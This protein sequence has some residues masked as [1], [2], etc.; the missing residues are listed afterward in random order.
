MSAVPYLP[1]ATEQSVFDRLVEL[2]AHSEIGNPASEI[3]MRRCVPS[4]EPSQLRRGCGKA[5]HRWLILK[6]P[7][8]AHAHMVHG[9]RGGIASTAG[10]DHATVLG[11]VAAVQPQ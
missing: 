9:S 5:L 8:L 1:I 6:D 10:H 3:E 4:W 2:V 11:N 7:V